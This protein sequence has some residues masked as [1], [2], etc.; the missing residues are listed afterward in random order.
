MLFI[1]VE[2]LSM[3]ITSMDLQIINLTN[4]TILTKA[5]AKLIF[6]IP[7]HHH[8]RKILITHVN[9]LGISSLLSRL[10]SITIYPMIMDLILASLVLHMENLRTIP[11]LLRKIHK[12]NLDG[13]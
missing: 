12:S 6:P 13:N 9:P 10:K 5:P 7:P 3:T 11:T 4:M 1:L 2:V 8:I